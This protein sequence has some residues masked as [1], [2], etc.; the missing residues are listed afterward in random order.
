MPS[1]NHLVDFHEETEDRRDRESRRLECG[2][3]SGNCTCDV[4]WD[5][6]E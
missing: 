3:M 6:N 2:C 5:R 1:G 4:A